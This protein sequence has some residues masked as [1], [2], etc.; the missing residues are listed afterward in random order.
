[1]STVSVPRLW[2]G[3][4]VVVAGSGPSLTA[5]DLEFCRER[6]ARTIVVNDAY[7]LAP[8]AD[9]MYAADDKYWRW[10]NGAPD[11]KGLKYT[12]RP[13]RKEWPGLMTVLNTGREGLELVPTGVRTGFHSGYQAINLAF[14]L[15]ASRVVLLGCDMRGDHFFGSHRDKSRPPFTAGIQAYE[16]L[17]QPLKAAGVDV[18]NCTPRSAIKAF[19][20]ASLQDVFASQLREAS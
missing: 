5:A 20:M 18:V 15:G 8:W 17:V 14:H 12:I 11:F 1:M 9:V 13:C 2:P 4:T 10:E 19:P 7:K 3:S 6:G 16:T